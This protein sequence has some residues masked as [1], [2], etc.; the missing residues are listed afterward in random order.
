MKTYRLLHRKD[1]R[2]K[3]ETKIAGN[4]TKYEEIESYLQKRIEKKKQKRA[5]KLWDLTVC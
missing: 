1:C 4:I 2:L 3:K 5:S